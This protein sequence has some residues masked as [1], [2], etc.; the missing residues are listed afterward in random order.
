MGTIISTIAIPLWNQPRL[1]YKNVFK[2]NLLDYFS[3][4]IL[5]ALLTIF[6][7]LIS[8]QLCNLIYIESTFILLI[9]KGVICIIVPSI[10]YILILHRKEEFIQLKIR[11]KSII[12][13]SYS[14]FAKI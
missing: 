9:I 10:I 3:K 12:I 6:S 8:A 7:G 1:V 5:Y 4:Y 2:K 11:I 13:K 14:R